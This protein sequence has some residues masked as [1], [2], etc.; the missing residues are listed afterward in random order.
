MSKKVLRKGEKLTT[1]WQLITNEQVRTSP[2]DA[3]GVLVNVSVL[4]A[5]YQT[6][7]GFVHVSGARRVV[8]VNVETGKSHQRPQSF[9]GETAWSDADRAF[10]DI[11]SEL[12]YGR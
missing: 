6:R 4:H 10:G 3:E 5:D 8:A 12:R 1:D 9:Y 11:V 2:A 7:D